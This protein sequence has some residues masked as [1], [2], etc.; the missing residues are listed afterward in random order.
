MGDWG[1]GPDAFDARLGLRLR[2]TRLAAGMSQETFA[3]E[4]GVTFQ[5]VQNYEMARNRISTST[6]VRA[7]RALGVHPGV[8]LCPGEAR[9]PLPLTIVAMVAADDEMAEL[10]ENYADMSPRQRKALDGVVCGLAEPR[11]TL[12]A[13][14]KAPASV[15]RTKRPHRS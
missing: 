1:R 14:R 8:I 3:R 12:D 9:E 7:A 5:Q 6:V 2:A 10:V 4:I 13:A 15:V 11:E